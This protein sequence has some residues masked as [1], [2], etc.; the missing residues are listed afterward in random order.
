MLQSPGECP[1]VEH[2]QQLGQLGQI[3]MLICI[4]WIY[5]YSMLTIVH[6]HDILDYNPTDGSDGVCTAVHF[7]WTSGFLP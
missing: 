5:P 1:K 3:G 2:S 6:I 7:Q 4:S